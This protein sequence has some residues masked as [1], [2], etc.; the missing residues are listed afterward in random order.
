MV[1][2]VYYSLSGKTA[3]AA[4]NL[5]KTLNAESIRIEDLKPR[6]GIIGFIRSGFESSTSRLPKIK[7]ISALSEAGLADYSDVI[8]LGPIW[9]SNICSPLRSFLTQYGQQIR[10]YGLV[11]TCSDPASQQEKARNSVQQLCGKPAAYQ[12]TICSADSDFERKIAA[13]SRDLADIFK[14]E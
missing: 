7:P 9:A 12:K 8:L 14:G 10:R 2:V 5:S 4:E 6:R 1:L 13:A 11:L 3:A